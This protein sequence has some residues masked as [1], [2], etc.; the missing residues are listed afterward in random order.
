MYDLVLKNAHVVDPKN[1]IN[2]VID[3]AIRDGK[4][5]DV[6]VDIAS[7]LARR[8]LD[9]SEK[10]LLP[11]IIDPHVHVSGWIGRK[12]GYKMMAKAGV[13][14]ALDLAGPVEDIIA[15]M[16]EKGAGLN[17][18]VLHAIVPESNISGENPS[19]GAI[20]QCVTDALRRG[21]IGIKILG[22]H[23]PLTPDATVAAIK[24]ANEHEAYVAFHAGTTESKSDLKGCKEAIALIGGHS[25]HLAHVNSYCR[26]LIKHPVDEVLEVFALLEGKNHI[27][28]ESYLARINGTSGTCVG[29]QPTSH[30]TR[31]CLAMGGFPPSLTGL[32]QAILEGFASVTVTR[33]G[34]NVLIHGQEG[35]KAWQKAH[36]NITISFEV[37]NP[38]SLFLCAT[39]KDSKNN[40][41]IDAFSTD[42]GGIPRNCI[43]EKGLLLVQFRA[44]S[45]AEFVI[46]SSY[47]ASRMLGLVNK[48][49]LGIGA[50]ADITGVDL[51]QRKAILGVNGGNI[52]MIDGHVIGEQG[53]LL[54]TQQGKKYLEKQGTA[55]QEIDVSQGRFYTHK[56]I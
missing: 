26:G 50:D 44:I 38:Q 17:I 27:I 15:G 37:N 19:H 52:I 16:R 29:D 20:E 30:V 55:Y 53:T 24:I 28:T 32:H 1:Q 48:G 7:D 41:V 11:G 36:T 25:V 18:A 42:G 35:V 8:M 34:E 5:A 39:S 9:L 10:V 21:A 47:N 23:Y 14:T 13:I 51:K 54:T 6:R 33:N 4:I 56:E 43:V 46:K 45:L 3:L 40:F 2:G 31:N 22:G 12:E 49:H